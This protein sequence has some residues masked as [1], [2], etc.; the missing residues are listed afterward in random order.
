MPKAKQKRKQFRHV[1]INEFLY[2]WKT[3]GNLNLTQKQLESKK[4]KRP[5]P[6]FSARLMCH[7][8]FNVRP[9]GSRSVARRAAE[10]HF[11]VHS[12][13][14]TCLQTEQIPSRNS[15]A[16]FRIRLN[17]TSAKLTFAFFGFPHPHEQ[18]S[19]DILLLR[20]ANHLE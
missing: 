6:Q 12:S 17:Q 11:V 5:A 14:T 4:L 2:K 1:C 13:S 18:D 20:R 8:V 16:G 15:K 9:L 10:E 7:V 3:V 19:F